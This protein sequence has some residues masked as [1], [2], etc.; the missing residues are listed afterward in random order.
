MKHSGTSYVCNISKYVLSYDVLIY[1]S[2]K[3][4]CFFVE[5]MK[6]NEIESNNYRVIHFV[7]VNHL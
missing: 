7:R 3:I 6:L 4:M 5:N 2:L 1:Q